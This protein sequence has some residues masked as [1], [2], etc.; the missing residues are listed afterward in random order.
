VV[1]GFGPL[2]DGGAG[3]EVIGVTGFRLGGRRFIE[4]LI[5]E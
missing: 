3:F 5:E 1:I 4:K 2:G